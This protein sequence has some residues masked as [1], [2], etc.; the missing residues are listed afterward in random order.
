MV[1]LFVAFT[2]MVWCRSHNLE[3]RKSHAEARTLSFAVEHNIPVSKVPELIQY[4]KE[5]AKD[6]K[7]LDG[8]SM[9]RTS[10]S[11]KMVYG[12]GAVAE[13]RLVSDMKK[14]KFSL[15]I[16]ECTSN[17]NN[18][19]VSIMASYFSPESGD[20]VYH[21]YRS[22]TMTDVNAK[23]LTSKVLLCLKE[24][25]IP[26]ENLVSILSDSANYMRGKKGG[27]ETLVRQKA[28]HL[29]D[30]DGD[31][32][33]HVHNASKVFC[34]H[35]NRIV[36]CLCGDL[37]TEFKYSTDLRSYLQEICQLLDN[38]YHIPKQRVPHRWLSVLDVI[39]SNEKMLDAMTVMYWAW[40]PD[41]DCYIYQD[42]Y[43]SK[44]ASLPTKAKLQIKNIIRVCKT[45]KLTED[46]QKRKDRI[47]ERLF[48]KRDS[49]LVH[50]YMYLSVLPLLKSFI[51]T[52]EQK[53]PMVH[54]VHEE[55][56]SL[57][58]HFLACFMKQEV[59]KNVTPSQLKRLNL[60]QK[61]QQHQPGEMFV[62][63]RANAILNKKR[64][65]INEELSTFLHVLQAAYVE[66]GEYL[67]RKLPLTNEFLRNVQAIDP[68]LVHSGHSQV[69]KNLKRLGNHFPQ[70][71]NQAN[72]DQFEQEV[73]K[74]T[75]DRNLP[76]P[77]TV[78]RKPV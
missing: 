50:V 56:M 12:L 9:G 34:S 3:D 74:I 8:I 41:K 38:Q 24:D 76:S 59:L 7:A 10:A 45:K 67:I 64:R 35:F 13:K 4:A 72:R 51:L 68:L 62:G 46:G 16:D 6:H 27:F 1:L 60:Q 14:N 11:Y 17:N 39:E 20:T 58:S 54:R 44:V 53:K 29:L 66:T 30:I 19:V 37:H 77:Q 22:F 23:E 26:L 55:H 65:V 25:E 21:H 71:I 5:M 36:E 61:D 47:V 43:D 57:L 18:K 28:P 31:V 73:L 40:I 15:N 49:T 33:H 2:E 52:F 42:I 32:C 78:D 63:T 48:V 70:V 69:A 75:T